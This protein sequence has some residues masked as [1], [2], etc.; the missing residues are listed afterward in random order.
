MFERVTILVS[1]SMQFHG[2]SD[3]NGTSITATI[4][5][6]IITTDQCYLTFLPRAIVAEEMQFAVSNLYLKRGLQNMDHV[7]DTN[8]TSFY[9]YDNLRPLFS[10]KNDF[11]SNEWSKYLL[12]Q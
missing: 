9:K 7:E 10:C 6:D 4:I 2:R 1:G 5:T 3:I 8:G 12:N 11:L